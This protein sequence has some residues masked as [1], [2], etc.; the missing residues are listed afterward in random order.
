MDYQHCDLLYRFADGRTKFSY[1]YARHAGQG[2]DHDAHALD[3]VVVVHH[4]DS[5]AAGV[6]CAVVCGDSVIAGSESRHQLLR[7]PDRGQ[8]A[9]SVAQG[10]VV[11]ALAAP[12]LVFRTSRGI[13]R[14]S[15]WDGRD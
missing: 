12:V 7:A 4:G 14:D 2:H 9:S 1:D 6:R 3:G 10:R 8:W 5:W 13:Y 11:P 15:A